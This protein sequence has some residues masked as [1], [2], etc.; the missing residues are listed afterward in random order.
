MKILITEFMENKSIEILKKNFDITV[1]LDLSTNSNKL[2]WS[3][4]QS[5][6]LEVSYDE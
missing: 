1:D 5:I 4:L 6:N 2:N 3:D